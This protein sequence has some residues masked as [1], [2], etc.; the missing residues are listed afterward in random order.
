MRSEKSQ[1]EAIARGEVGAA[2]TPPDESQMSSRGLATHAND[3]VS[4]VLTLNSV[5]SG[6]DVGQ[7]D[8]VPQ[9]RDGVEVA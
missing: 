9:S 4:L 3:D 6:P 7:V 1:V 2:L 5:G 8:E